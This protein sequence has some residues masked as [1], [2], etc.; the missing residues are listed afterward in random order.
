[1]VVRRQTTFSFECQSQS[2]SQSS[3]KSVKSVILYL[4]WFDYLIIWLGVKLFPKQQRSYRVVSCRVVSQQR[5]IK[6]HS[7][8]I[9]AWH[10]CLNACLLSCLEI[11]Q[12][13]TFPFHFEKKEFNWN[14][15]P[16]LKH[17]FNIIH[18][19]DLIWFHSIWFDLII[20]ILN[21]IETDHR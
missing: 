19:F 15:N 14:P 9:I 7:I 17:K 16:N 11:T 5:S 10:A 6:R 18:S 21:F 4:I 1:M 8:I 13:F 3:V 2:V 20:S 12:P